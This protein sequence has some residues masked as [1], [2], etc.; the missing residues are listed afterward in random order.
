[1]EQKLW[2]F[3]LNFTLSILNVFYGLTH[4]Q[5]QKE[6]DSRM[7]P[8]SLTVL[9]TE[10]CFLL[11]LHYLAGQLGGSLF[12]KHPLSYLVAINLQLR[13]QPFWFCE[14][15][16]SPRLQDPRTNKAW[17]SEAFLKRFVLIAC[18]HSWVTKPWLLT[19]LLK[20]SST[21]EALNCLGSRMIFR[22]DQDKM[23]WDTRSIQF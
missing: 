6:S 20:E 3:T 23:R 18:L 12:P 9:H 8:F 21:P 4:H 2:S 7:S 1:M 5:N 22:Y 17:V 10:S 15:K 13:Q 14:T 11:S 19:D 16:K